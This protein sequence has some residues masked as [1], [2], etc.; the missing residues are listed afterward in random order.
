MSPARVRG[1]RAGTSLVEM[2]L[3]LALGG[4]ITTAAVSMI[5]P[6]ND[7]AREATESTEIGEGARSSIDLIASSIRRVPAGGVLVATR[8]SVVVALP[9]GVGMFCAND[10]SRLTAYLGLAGRPLNVAAVD[11]YALREPNGT[12]TFTSMAGTSLFSGAT[13]GKAPCVAAGG[14]V[15]GVD[16]DYY[17]FY[18]STSVAPGQGLLVWDRHTFRFGPSALDPATRGF[19]YGQTGAP[20]LEVAFELHANS[21]FE[22]RLRGSTTWYASVSATYAP[23]IEVVRVVAG[24]LYDANSGLMSREIPLLNSE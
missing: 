13:T 3:V 17:T 5:A 19:F 6:T 21:R 7:L 14:G 16:T 22:Y 10:G 1:G 15:A 11:G 20:L 8:D 9:L 2:L 4:L 12:W 18:I 24:G 23:Y